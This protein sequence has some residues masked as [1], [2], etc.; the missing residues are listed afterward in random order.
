[1]LTKQGWKFFKDLSETDIIC[2]LNPSTQV[3]EY[4][5]PSAIVQFT[6]HKNLVSIQNN[7]LDIMVTPDH[8]MYVNSQYNARTK[9]NNFKFIKARDLQHQSVIKRT[10]TWLGIEQKSFLIPSVAIGHYEGRQVVLHQT[11]ELK[12]PM[13]SWLAFMG[14]WL[15]DGCA[16]QGYSVT[17][18]QKIPEKTQKIQELL[19]FL[20][21]KFS[22]TNDAFNIYNKQLHS[23]LSQLGKAPEKYVPEF[24]KELSPRQ[25]AIFLKWFT[26]GDGTMMR[27]GFRIFYTSS[28]KLAD[29]IQEL[30]LKIERVGT[31]KTRNP[32]GKVWIEDH[33]VDASRV[34]YEVI[35]RVK[36][37]NSWI[38]KRDIKK[39]DYNGKVYCAEVKNHIMYV[40]RNGKP[41]WC[42]NTLMY[43]SPP[44]EIF[45]TTLLKIKQELVNSGYIGYVDI[46]CIANAKGIYPLEFTCRFGYPTISIQMEGV[47]S[48]WGA[49]LYSLAE[50][51]QTE[52][53]TRKGFQVGVCV[54]VP[55]FPYKD[56][57]ESF[58]YKDLSIVFKKNNLEGLHLGDIKLVNGVWSIAG[59]TGYVMVITGSGQTV[60]DARRQVYARLKN[61]ILQGMYYRT[62]IGTKWPSD[63]DKLQTWGYLY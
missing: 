23:Y 9:K 49:F 35:E 31:I 50:G 42:G 54:V 29:D 22:K 28:K 51:A 37:L 62:D 47:T 19:E 55:P 18:A 14:I 32:R 10:G 17:I 3:I 5:K 13:D 63:S 4:N 48:E 46:N 8:N 61:I 24:I 43:W 44:N 57:V 21:F 52:L 60:E 45:R 7:T 34:Q 56:K 6:H 39:M 2:T 53:K 15:S 16:S 1:V 41:Y 30:L 33:F 59:M 27:N 58:I 25:I 40:R 38:D 36:K 11:D 20:P 26:L 12:I